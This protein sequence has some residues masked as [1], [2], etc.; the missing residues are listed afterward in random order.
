MN[1]LPIEKRVQ[2]VTMLVEGMSMRSVSRV[3]DVSINTVTKLL[4]DVGAACSEY[5]GKTMRNLALTDIQVD[6]IWAF[7][8]AKAKN[9]PADADSALRL[10]DCYTYT[11]ID[12]TTKLMP[13]YMLGYRTAG[14][15]EAFMEDLASRL[16]NRVQLT[17][18]GMSGYPAAV[19]KAFGANV[20]YAVLNKS[21]AAGPPAK[22]A[23]RRYSPAECIGCTKEPKIGIPF[24]ELVSTSNVER[25][26]LTM[27]MRMGMQR[28]T[29][30]TNGFS[31]KIEM[32]M[33]AVSLHFMHYNFA[34]IHKTLK[35]TPAMQ[36]GIAAHVWSI[37]E[38]VRLVPEPD[39]KKRGPYKAR[40]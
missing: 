17:T 9:V 3:A 25:A 14:C 6:E 32:H 5:Q 35:V 21:Y 30:L 10:G 28:F 31:K 37:E 11:A 12:R 19:A 23:K 4:A 8:G 18:D 29:R 15:A 26:N 13:C 36:A 38:I 2:I 1:R 27:R 24:P 33:H 34:R 7:I 16:S 20:D 40:A 39:A 22:E